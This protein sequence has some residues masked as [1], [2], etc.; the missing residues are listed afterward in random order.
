MGKVK[1]EKT[2]KRTLK[3]REEENVSSGVPE[4]PKTA[5]QEISSLLDMIRREEK[6]ID[7]LDEEEVIEM[8]KRL[9]PYAGEIPIDHEKEACFAYSITNMREEYMKKL[10][11]TACT[12]FI[13]RRGD[14]WGVPKAD[15]VVPVEELDRNE[16]IYDFVES[17]VVAGRVKLNLQE[18]IRVGG[19]EGAS[20]EETIFNKLK[21]VII[22]E[23]LDDIFQFNTDAHIRSTYVANPHDT[24]RK[25][26]K[27]RKPRQ[28]REKR[29]SEIDEELPAGERQ[30]EEYKR[31]VNVRKPD[32]LFYHFKNYIDMNYDAVRHATNNL[33]CEKPDV[34]FIVKIYDKFPNMEEYRKFVDE[35]EK[36][37]VL[38]IDCAP[39]NK[40]CWL[41]PFAANREKTLFYN[42]ETRILQEMMENAERQQKM[43]ADMIAKKRSDLRRK[44]IEEAG[45]HDAKVMEDY[46]REK[47]KEHKKRGMQPITELERNQLELERKYIGE[48]DKPSAECEET[49]D[50]IEVR[51][52]VHDTRK[53]RMTTTTF[54]TAAEKPDFDYTSIKSGK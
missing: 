2:V 28:T 16:I 13:Y 14:E 30:S 47:D 8:R 18:E 32:D 19:G 11:M 34:D 1:K 6:S 23:F 46:I 27:K 7:E 17:N 49:P 15:Y 29:T 33:H 53:K 10:L 4:L 26:L 44:N 9:N 42:S 52:F 36:A 25:P 31:M 40:F 3:K 35:N 41:G 43:G 20:Q 39:A 22:R 45:E 24:S 21:R 37:T 38:N 50:T 51:A 48:F 54:L 5:H 12:G